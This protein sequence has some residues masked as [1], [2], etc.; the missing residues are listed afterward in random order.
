MTQEEHM[1]S[2]AHRFNRDF[3]KKYTAG[4][5]EHNGLLYEV[6]IE[7]LAQFAKEEVL[8]QAS[9]IY[10]VI[11]K[12]REALDYCEKQTGVRQCKNCGLGK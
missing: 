7:Q 2:I 6:P 3:I 9:Y 12:V 5:K 1:E 10:S 4:A 11:D 8:D